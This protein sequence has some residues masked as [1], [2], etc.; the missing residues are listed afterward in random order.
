ML[1]SRGFE[2]REEDEIICFRDDWKAATPFANLNRAI[3]HAKNTLCPQPARDMPAFT[4][5]G[6]QLVA[7]H[8]V[9]M[10]AALTQMPFAGHNHQAV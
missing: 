5:G 7:N 4:I 3:C 6:A 1:R 10:T 8:D 2:L 9:D